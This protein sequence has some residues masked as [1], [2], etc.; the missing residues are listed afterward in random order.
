VAWKQAQETKVGLEEKS[1]LFSLYK[2]FQNEILISGLNL[3]AKETNK[4]TMIA[5][6][7]L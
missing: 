7:H 1:S 5:M 4:L 3:K 2:V 6:E